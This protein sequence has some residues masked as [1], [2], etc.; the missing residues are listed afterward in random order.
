[1]IIDSD[2]GVKFRRN[3]ALVKPGIITVPEE[4]EVSDIYEGDSGAE[5][6]CTRPKRNVRYPKRFEDYDL[7]I[8]GNM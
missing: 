4:F 3:T 5:L 8:K 7:N 6:E 1:M 2:E